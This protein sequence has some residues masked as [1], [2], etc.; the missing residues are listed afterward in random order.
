MSFAI[1]TISK[2]VEIEHLGNCLYRKQ[3]AEDRQWTRTLICES[4]ETAQDIE[5]T[6]RWYAP[7]T[8][9]EMKAVLENIKH[10]FQGQFRFQSWKERV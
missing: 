8:I 6:I 3:G 5:A 10:R 4:A 7:K 1:H 9:G 2:T